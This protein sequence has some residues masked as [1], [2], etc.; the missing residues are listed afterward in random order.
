M[1]CCFLGRPLTDYVG[2]KVRDAVGITQFIEDYEL[3][4]IIDG[5]FE[6]FENDKEILNKDY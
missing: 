4:D 1:Y 3:Y 2:D 6:Y 5:I